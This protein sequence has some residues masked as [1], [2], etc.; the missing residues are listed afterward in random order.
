LYYQLFFIRVMQG[1]LQEA[2]RTADTYN[3]L[4]VTLDEKVRGL[5][6]Q[7]LLA[8]FR[9]DY[10]DVIQFARTAFALYDAEDV[11]TR[12]HDLH[13]LY[14]VSCLAMQKQNEA[15]QE[16]LVMEKI[17]KEN[18][19]S[20]HNY[21]RGIYKYFLH[22]QAT[23][24]ARQGDVNGLLEIMKTMD[25][26]P[27]KIKDVQTIFDYPFFCQSFADLLRQVKRTDLGLERLNQALALNPWNGFVHCHLWQEYRRRGNSEM[28]EK[29]HQLAQQAW[30]GAD[31]EWKK[32]YLSEQRN[33]KPA[34]T[35]VEI[36]R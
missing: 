30:A 10:T 22:L 23:L 14:A 29:H 9:K 1:Q 4:A 11:A 34:F 3:H 15:N 16:A 5:Y 12:N 18:Q 21:R 8:Y 26:I 13:W 17:I 35:E 31:A 27:E 6:L 25:G 28:A 32:I 20:A 24:A 33:Q 19:I 7:A 36:G 2:E